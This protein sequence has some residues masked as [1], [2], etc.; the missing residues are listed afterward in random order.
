MGL[1]KYKL[2]M[3]TTLAKHLRESRKVKLSTQWPGCR[4]QCTL[5]LGRDEVRKGTSPLSTISW[6]RLCSFWNVLCPLFSS[7]L[8]FS[9]LKP[10]WI[11][12]QV[13]SCPS[14]RSIFC[15]ACFV[16]TTPGSANLIIPEWGNHKFKQ[17]LREG[18]GFRGDESVLILAE[19][20]LVPFAKQH[21]I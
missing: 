11:F 7:S 17:V 6:L 21:C 20:S 2:L 19:Q 10:S 13:E 3:R 15:L 16:S 8:S 18:A 9:V 14:A 5:A 12:H 4:C 1:H